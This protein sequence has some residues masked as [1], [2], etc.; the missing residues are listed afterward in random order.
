MGR[1]GVR[2]R[3]IGILRC[4]HIAQ[5]QVREETECH[6]HDG[7]TECA[8]F[9]NRHVCIRPKA[10]ASTS[11]GAAESQL[12]IWSSLKGVGHDPTGIFVAKPMAELLWTRT[13]HV[14]RS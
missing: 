11:L 7:G 10:D 1:P 2:G 12:E 4:H 13:R 6:A 8:R 9:G 5:N 14:E 3:D